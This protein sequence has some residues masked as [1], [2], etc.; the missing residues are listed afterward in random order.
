MNAITPA[1]RISAG[2]IAI[3]SLATFALQIALSVEKTGS[4]FGA[5]AA[6]SR[7]FTILTN[8]AVT[9]VML[10]LALG[11]VPGHRLMLALVT[12]IA[13]VGIVF[14]AV[15][16]DLQTFSGL[17]AVTNQGFHTVIPALTVLWWVVFGGTPGILWRD[18]AWVLPWPVVYTA[19]ALVRGAV[20]GAY[21]Y[22]FLDVAQIG[23]LMLG[24]NVLA[25]TAI[26][27]VVGAI[28]VG[29]AKAR[30]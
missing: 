8:A 9:V 4:L 30:R 28:F 11:R 15:L 12:A 14:H 7:Y 16:A 26:F 1:A 5:F 21:P 13:M 19:Y 25:L 22:P 2:V 23:G 3:V 10:R 27:L 20:T 24:V 29:I 18:L 17:D 6:L